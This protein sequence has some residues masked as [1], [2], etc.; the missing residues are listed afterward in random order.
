MATLTFY[1]TASMT[2]PSIW[3]GTV[4]QATSTQLSLNNFAGSSATY[5]GNNLSYSGS[6]VVGGTVTNYVNYRN[7]SIDYIATGLNIDAATLANFINSGNLIGAQAL[8][9]IG[10][11]LIT[12][13]VYSDTLVGY[14]GDDTFNGG[15]GND[16]II[17]GPGDDTA[18]Y[19][20]ARNFYTISAIDGGYQVSGPN[21]ID[22]L[23]SVENLRFSD[24]TIS[25]ASI[26][27]IA[28][29]VSSF[30]PADGASRIQTNQNIILTFNETIV[31]GSGIIYLRTGSATGS[32]VEQFNISTSNKISLSD[33]K[34]IID[35]TILLESTTYYLTIGSGVVKD[36]S[37]NNYSGTSSYDFRTVTS[38]YD[39]IFTTYQNYDYG[40][41][42]Q[43]TDIKI[44]GTVILG[45]LGDDDLFGTNE[46]DYVAG[47]QGLDLIM[48]YGGNDF[49]FPSVDRSIGDAG[50]GI[51][52]L[53]FTRSFSNSTIKPFLTMNPD[54]LL[55]KGVTVTRNGDSYSFTSFNNVERLKFSDTNVA[56][57]I[58][59]YE[60]AGQAY[61]LYKAAFN[62]IPDEEG[63]GFWIYAFDNGSQLNDVAQ[64]FIN[65]D[66]FPLLYGFNSDNNTF[67]SRLYNN[68]LGREFDQEGY[69]FWLAALNN[70]LP[71]N[72]ILAQFSESPENISNVIDL[73]G[74][75][76]RYEEWLG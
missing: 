72:S 37:G 60:N 59:R 14:F 42:Y 40:D 31:K 76:I 5:Y 18:I 50:D 53:V 75:G 29:F 56:L 69:N 57:D 43:T 23:Y 24:G 34:L 26:D 25:L 28:P 48:T 58:G 20:Q 38:A 54:A 41:R 71:R 12:G 8:A 36:L 7:F 9:L 35:P 11:D 74:Q 19:T 13:S 1:Q 46:T 39:H 73:I 52:T 6:T 55:S 68:V 22:I 17:G 15:A 4:T 2:N 45:T 70:G 21:G 67:L 16:S 64:G 61:R 10:N 30:S 44:P 27:L 62:R 32:I 49:I 63:L 47:Y 3:Y 66:E 33:N 51:D 65:S